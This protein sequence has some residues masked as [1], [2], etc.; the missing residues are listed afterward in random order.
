MN[1]P[2]RSNTVVILAAG[3]IG[4]P[5]DP[6]AGRAEE[7]RP[8]TVETAW[9][10]DL[11][12]SPDIPPGVRPRDAV[13]LKP[14]AV[15]G[16]EQLRSAFWS[17]R[18]NAPAALL[19]NG[20]DPNSRGKDGEPILHYALWCNY[21]EPL[22]DLLRAGADPNLPDRNG[23][24][25]LG[26]A[27]WNGHE[28]AVALLLRYG[29]DPQGKR[30]D[31][32]TNL[33]YARWVENKKIIALLEAKE[34]DP[35]K[36]TPVRPPVVLRR[37][38]QVFGSARFRAAGGGQALVYTADSRQLVAG[39]ERGGIRF[40]DART[41]ELRN[42]IAAHD[43]A[44]L[45]LARIPN[46]SALVSSGYDR[47]TRLWDVETSREL[48][49]LRGGSHGTAVS[50]DGRL[51]F[52]GDHV[53][54]IESTKPPKLGPR[55]RQFKGPGGTRWSFFTPDSRYLVVGREATGI[56]VWD[57]AKDRLH[58]LKEFTPAAAKAI[59]WQDL[60]AAVDI[61]GAKPTDVLA[62]GS[63]QYT[64]VAAAPAVLTAFAQTVPSLNYDTLAMACSPDG[65]YLAMFGQES[66]I[67]VYDLENKKQ[68]YPHDGHTAAVLAVSASPDGKLIASGGNDRTVRVWD[69]K[70]GKQVAEIPTG[71]FVYSVRFSPDGRLLAI[72][73]NS[74]NLYLW[75]V[76]GRT[77]GTYQTSGRVTGMAFDARGE[78]LVSIGFEVHVLDVKTRT[79]RA[80]VSAGNAGQGP[81]AVSPD[82]LIVGGVRAMSASQTFLVPPAWV[83]GKNALTEKKGLFSEAMGHR[84]FIDAVAFSPDG[85]ILA[86]SSDAAIRLWDMRK[87]R[88]IGGKMCGHTDSPSDLRFSPD[89]KW[90]ASAGWDGT[91][92]L[93][94]AP[95]GRP[96]LVLE[97]DVD[98]VS[99]VDFTP[100]GQLVTANWDGTVHLWDLA[101][102][103]A[104]TGAK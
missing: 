15:P 23:D 65:Q 39:D 87:R 14:R 38:D 92:R 66:R 102:H 43:Y 11:D 68:K 4:G 5:G 36:P 55:G 78:V 76:G 81:L 86:A 16:Y 40:F 3:L 12:V 74:S 101:K 19:A 31:G 95:S 48:M 20:A 49:R 69:R 73:D 10:R 62:L 9:L 99:G 60:A 80:K 67:D 52:T 94:E 82:G 28:Q 88:P 13:T 33:A 2:R 24:T 77:L 25:P 56:W 59:T 41:G 103:R 29:A 89:G 61:G 104:S 34:P 97:A 93:W 53:W 47:T 79:T 1:A 17:G 63:N 51:L 98:R 21:P 64:V 91:A 44:V 26:R 72:G 70:T 75:D 57:L 58:R 100:D 45:G 84:S 96:L 71:S 42:V 35:V 30:K 83:F 90:L 8:P 22:E 46:P 37:P 50:P 6:T 32:T 54:D 85:S 18:A 27:I 7:K